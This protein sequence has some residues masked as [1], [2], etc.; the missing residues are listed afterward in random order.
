MPHAVQPRCLIFDLETVP[1]H[2]NEAE[3]I[4]KVG[5]LRPDTGDSFEAATSKQLAPSLVRLDRMCEGASFILG[6]NIVAHDLP[7][8]AAAAPASPLLERPAIDTLRLSP[9]AFP[10]NPYHRLIKDYKLIRDNLNSPLSDCRATLTLFADQQDAFDRLATSHDNELRCYQALVAPR[11]GAGLGNFF[12]ALTRQPP[13]TLDHVAQWLPSLLAETDPSLSRT[14]KVCGTRLATLVAHDLEQPDLHWPIAYA[15]AW[16]RVSGGNSVLAPWV[17]HQFP[18]VGRLIAELRD[19]PC[20]DPACSYCRTTHDPRHE[21][22]RYFGFDDFRHE[23]DGQ[24][25]QHDIVLA[26]MRGESVL[27]VL[28]TGGGKSICYQLPALN[29]YHRNGSLTIIISPLQSLMKDQV[30]GLLARNVQCAAALNGLLTMPERADVLEKIQMGDIGLLLV[31]PEQFRNKAFRKAIA[32]RQIGAWIFDE[33][34]CLSKWGNDFRPDYLYAARFIREFTAKDTLAPIGCFTATAKQDVLDDIRKHFQDELGTTFSAFIGTPERPN[35][36]F[37]VF[38]VSAGEKFVRTH[39]LLAA[40]LGAHQGGAVVFVASRKKAEDLA[41]FL[42]GQR[43]T[44]KHFH[45]G[46]Q[47]H[48]KKDIQ[49]AFIHG[50]LRVIVATNAFGMGV[51]KQDVRLVVHAD[52]PGSLENYL[53]EAGRAGRD[54]HDARCVLLYD[55]QD[56]ETQFGLSERSRLNQKDIQ[57]IL[58]KLRFEAGRRKGGQLVITAGEILQDDLVNTSFEADDRDAETKVVTA[59]A[60]L[61]RGQFLR[62]EEN[63]T[64]VFPARLCLKE[65]DADTRLQHAGLSARR[66]EEYRAILRFLYGAQ[67]DQRIDTDQLMQ[68]T[69]QTSEEVSSALRQLEALGLLENDAQLTLYLRHGTAGASSERLKQCLALE[70]ALFAELREQAPDADHGDWQDINLP[71]LTASLRERGQQPDLLPLHVL[72]LLRSLALDRDGDSQQRSS[73]ELR[74]QTRDHLKLRIRG[75]HTW[76]QVE[77]LGDKR[78][79]IAAALLPFLIAKLPPGL[80]G[81]DL[82]VNTTFGELQRL[83]AEDL[84][85]SATIKPEQRLK[86][87]EHVLLYLHHQEILTLNHGMTVMRRAMTIDINPDKQGQRY[88]KD[89]Y[90]RLDEHYRERRIQV[91]VMRE[92]AEIALREMADA[93]RLVM[94]YFTRARDEFLHHYFAG[95][96]DILQLATS[97]A[98]WKSIVDALDKVQK[99]IVTDHQD[100]NRLVLAGPGSGKTRVVVHRIAYLLRVRRVP[101][102]AIIALTFN[103]HAANEIRKRLFALVGNDAIGLTVLTYHAMAM[104][105]TGTR[106]ERRDNLVEGELDT[107]LDRAADLLDGRT[108]VEGEDDLRERLLAGYRYIVVDEYQDIDERQYRLVSALARRHS[109]QGDR[110]ADLC[111]L[112]VGDDDQ[113]IYQ[114]RGGSNRH[115]ERFCAEY[116]AEVSYLIDNYR[117]SRAIIAASNQ[118]IEQNDARLKSEHPIRIDR[119]RAELPDAGRWCDLDPE[120]SGRVLRIHLPAID[121]ATGNLQA[122]AVMAELQRVRALEGREDWQG[123]AVLAR[124]HRYLWPFQAWCEQR[125]VPYFLAADRQSML[126]LTRQR[127][128][129]SVVAQLRAAADRSLDAAN[130]ALAARSL[131]LDPVW[132]EFFDTAFDQLAGEFGGCHLAPATIIDWL[133]DY[134]REM[135]QQPRPGLFL[136][137]VHAAKGL[138]FRHVALLDGAWETSPDHLEEAR[139]LYYVGM[140][141]AEE[142]LTLCEFAPGNPFA[143]SLATCLQ[144]RDFNADHDPALDLHYQTLG[145][146][147]ID[148]G[149]PGRQAP[150]APM[151]DAIRRL[152]PGDALNLQVEDERLVI[153]NRDGQVVGRT[154]RS[155]RLEV[156]P[157]TCEVGGIVTRFRGDTD[158]DY[159]ATIKCEQWELVMPRLKGRRRG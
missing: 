82:L 101:A 50:E 145:L 158:P 61:E 29:R 92:Y 52:I 39:Q 146:K 64:K 112:A 115:I 75:G 102:A 70:E 25:M 152:E 21:L 94:H 56:I 28:A 95:K 149:F 59:I 19:T 72:R 14:L 7:I 126:P 69:G 88:V 136:G 47:P 66:L 78:R 143:S 90:Q 133:Y 132:R 81:K 127:A 53:Q 60:W 34:H 10:Q 125:G 58:G 8:L 6:H 71:P 49:D 36:H 106:F 18:A 157:D 142:T 156:E 74:Q 76:S 12:L 1:A 77:A 119:A 35:L 110:D 131:A 105:L 91:H 107:L 57:Q 134:A 15:L 80:R 43:W 147:D 159:L 67:A 111:I 137:T 55:P 13:V 121:R 139:R 100:R 138:E 124:S 154:S 54:Q 33:A 3:R 150:G 130:A 26:G 85:L 45:A 65:D 140:T 89:D 93:L 153:R 16:L 40:E 2:E 117:S 135:R 128:F 48:E 108:L 68:L 23:A 114:W 17:R 129:T 41:D 96:E 104:R 84:E 155:F 22:K 83:L 86:A 37:E 11:T 87:L 79:R 38:P 42:I 24:S 141:R 44:C 4:V 73:F 27:A 31:S 51:D 20:D 144:T 63:H 30:D 151:H 148:I 99:A 46:L 123:C 5:A 103:R 109:E 118:L 9:L 120:R 32:H 97:E 122:Q 116:A 62:R 98:S 113:N